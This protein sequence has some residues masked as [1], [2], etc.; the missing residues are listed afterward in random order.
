MGCRYEG[1]WALPEMPPKCM[2]QAYDNFLG[3]G[4]ELLGFPTDSALGTETRD[5]GAAADDG[6]KYW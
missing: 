2:A 5:G 3:V 1:L 6:E 4:V